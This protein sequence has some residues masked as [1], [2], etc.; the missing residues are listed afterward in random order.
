MDLQFSD[1]LTGKRMRRWKKQ[2]E[3]VIE[4]LT[5]RITQLGKACH[6]GLRYFSDDSFEYESNLRPRNPYDRYTG[7]RRA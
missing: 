3:S 6:T 4:N 1:I 2:A 7:R 5:R